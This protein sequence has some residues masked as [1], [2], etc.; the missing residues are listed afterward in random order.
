MIVIAADALR[1]LCGFRCA[2]DESEATAVNPVV[3]MMCSRL[4]ALSCAF[5]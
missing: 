2:G 3:P 5:V 4:G 1:S